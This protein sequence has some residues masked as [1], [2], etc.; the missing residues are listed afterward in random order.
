MN[1]DVDA[2]RREPLEEG[3]CEVDGI[4]GM[5]NALTAAILANVKARTVVNKRAIL[6]GGLREG[7]EYTPFYLQP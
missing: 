2:A 1:A 6:L 5:T 3:S 4:V 7:S